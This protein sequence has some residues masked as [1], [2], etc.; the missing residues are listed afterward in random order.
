MSDPTNPGPTTTADAAP[1]TAANV[2]APRAPASSAAIPREWLDELDRARH[3][4]AKFEGEL[5]K[6]EAGEAETKALVAQLNEKVALTEKAKAEIAAQRERDQIAT[7]VRDAVRDAD[8]IEVD[9]AVALLAPAFKLLD[10][11][12]V[13]AADGAAVADA[14][15]AWFG[16]RPHMVKPRVAAGSGAPPFPGSAPVVNAVTYD[17]RTAEGMT[18]FARSLTY[19]RGQTP[20]PASTKPGA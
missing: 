6:R 3:Q 4:A 11:K 1:L 5:K 19:A 14:V 2:A 10:G 17:L 13:A 8:A 16:K 12:V 15:K 7:A 20:A 9:D 18:G